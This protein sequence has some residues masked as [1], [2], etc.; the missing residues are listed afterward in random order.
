MYLVFFGKLYSNIGAYR[1]VHNPFTSSLSTD[2][3]FIW[4]KPWMRLD[5]GSCLLVDS[6]VFSPDSRLVGLH[7]A[8]LE[9]AARSSRCSTP[10]G[11]LRSRA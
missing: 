11:D 10:A 6:L 4:M 2:N 1:F 9:A 8:S 5:A 3:K 7:V